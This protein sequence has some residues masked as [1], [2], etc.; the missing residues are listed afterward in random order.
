MKKIRLKNSK[1]TSLT[2]SC[3]PG[4]W[5]HRSKKNFGFRLLIKSTFQIE[6]LHRTV[7]YTTVLQAWISSLNLVRHITITE[8]CQEG[9]RNMLKTDGYR[10][11]SSAVKGTQNKSWI[12]CIWLIIVRTATKHQLHWICVNFHQNTMENPLLCNTSMIIQC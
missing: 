9:P 6:F 11:N 7:M 1:P 10:P 8:S 5:L 4:A 3:N 2:I 12:Y